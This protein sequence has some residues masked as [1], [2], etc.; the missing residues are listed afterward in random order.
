MHCGTTT[1]SK[2]HPQCGDTIVPWGAPS[3]KMISF[4][5]IIAKINTNFQTMKGSHIEE[6]KVKM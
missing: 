2:S 4:V 1:T 3:M 5:G 6:V